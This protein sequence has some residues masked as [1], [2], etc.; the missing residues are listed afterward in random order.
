MLFLEAGRMMLSERTSE[1]HGMGI[2]SVLG[3]LWAK[4]ERSPY[5][6]HY[7]RLKRSQ[8]DSPDVIRSRQWDAIRN[9][10]VHS[11]GSVP[12][13]R[14]RFREAG[15]HPRDFQNLDDLRGFPL[16][17]KTDLRNHGDRLRSNLFDRNNLLC[18]RTSGSTGVS[19]EVL[20][21]ETSQQ[22]KRACTLR[23]NEWS[24][25]RFGE[26]VA[27]VWG[28]P[29]YAKRGWRGRL[30]N[31]LLDRATYLDTLKM[32][33]EALAQFAKKIQQ[34]KPTLIYGHAHSVFLF[35][36]YIRRTGLPG[37]RPRGVITTAMVLHNWQR[38]TIEE[39][40]GCS[41]TN[42][43]GCEEVSLIACECER[44]DG[45]HINAEGV[46]V[47]VLRDGAPA[48]PGEPGSIV[49]TDLRNRAM[50]IL[51]SQVGD[52]AVLTDR[53]CPCGRGLP[54]LE[55]L[56]GREADYVMTAAGE[57]IS[58][59]SLTENFALHVPGLAQ[60]QIIQETVKRFVFRIVRG[61]DFGAESISRIGELV[62]ERFGS[63]VDYE[64]EYVEAIPQETSGKYRFCISRVENPFTRRQEVAVQ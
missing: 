49:V 28:N 59:I 53:P 57:L 35:A 22:F 61:S 13:Y 56:E 9:L 46:Y 31:A 34:R 48:G 47:E 8:F 64:C 44:H 19:V 11:Y 43:Y 58:G 40:F 42:R 45:L 1:L 39:V 29:E 6:R 23:C 5:L 7:R 16:L 2:R 37:I 20:V 32:D 26:P 51:R 14:D 30:R 63:D 38:R 24:G 60:L 27:M 25:W 33:A 3:P 55:R 62:A 41:V 54:R 52:V 18:K 15:L 4:W 10:L 50:P 17:T 36:E 21:E 12:F